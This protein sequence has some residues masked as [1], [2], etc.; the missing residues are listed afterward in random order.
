MQAGVSMRS[1]AL[2]V[3][4]FGILPARGLVFLALCRALGACA[5]DEGDSLDSSQAHDAEEHVHSTQH[6]RLDAGQ[7]SAQA[8]QVEQGEPLDAPESGS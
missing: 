3:N 4:L 2:S 1:S 6:A 8:D 5:A 7:D